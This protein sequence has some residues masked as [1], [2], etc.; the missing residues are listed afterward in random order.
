MSEPFAIE[1]EFV[2]ANGLR[3]ELLTCG[4]GDRLALLL[5]G[6]P[7]VAE[8]WRAQMPVLA[9]LGYRV[10]APNQ[11]GYGATTRPWGMEAYAIEHLMSDV[12]GLIDDAH[13]R[14]AL[15]ETVLVAHD[16]GALV[17]WTFA[18]RRVRP[19]TRLVILN[20]PHPVCFARAIRRSPRQML[21]SWYVLFFQIPGLPDWALRRRSGEL[22]GRMMLQSST[23]PEQFPRALLEACCRNAA[24]PGGATAMLHWYRAALRGGGL[25]RQL[26]LGFP[27]IAVP[28][29][30]LWGEA[31]VALG[32]ETLE[33]TE[34]FA[35]H[36]TRVMLPGVSHWVQQDATDACNAALRDFLR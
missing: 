4:T 5:H 1:A 16:W 26:R 35:P 10:W 36:L 11:R 19:L 7:E 32:V 18:A 23:A 14:F 30:V 13:T 3:F 33:G 31:D 27:V 20:V 2:E 29:L 34:S 22:A 24:S 15:R 25:R 12:A 8:C 6:F 9:A 21:R 28:V 17:A